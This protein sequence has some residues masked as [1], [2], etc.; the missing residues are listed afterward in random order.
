MDADNYAFTRSELGE[1][2][3]DEIFP[4]AEKFY[5]RNAHEAGTSPFSGTFTRTDSD[6]DGY[7]LYCKEITR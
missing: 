3:L 4:A 6:K 1:Y 2:C 5:L 7:K